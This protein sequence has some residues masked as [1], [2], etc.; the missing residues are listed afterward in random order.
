M[1]QNLFC[2]NENHKRSNKMQK[3]VI[4][5]GMFI[6]VLSVV[7]CEQQQPAP[8][9]PPPIPGLV[10]TVPGALPA[11][12][13]LVPTVPGVVPTV[14]GAVPT[15]PGAVP[16]V[17]GLVPTV[18]GVVPTVPGVVPTAPTAA[19]PP[20]ATGDVLVDKLNTKKFEVS[21]DMQATSTLMKQ[22]SAKGK[23]QSYQVQL[24]GPPYCQTYVVSAA[25]TVKNIDL[26]LKDPTGAQ[27]AVDGAEGNVAVIAN[28][29]PAMPGMYQLTVSMPGDEGEFAIQVFSK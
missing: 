6:A 21:P 27:A 2:C 1:G 5:V 26:L 24:A 10:P 23:S 4:W 20:T 28:H 14:P 19:A 12:P 15:V 9:A 16:T 8:T 3:N 18:P 22:V 17:P 7:G 25:D 11:V 29:C 13:G